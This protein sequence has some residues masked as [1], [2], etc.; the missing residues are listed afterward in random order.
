MV[1]LSRCQRKLGAGSASPSCGW[2]QL[3]SIQDCGHRQTMLHWEDKPSS[4]RLGSG[5]AARRVG[6]GWCSSKR[7]AQCNFAV[8]H[9]HCLTGPHPKCGLTLD[10]YMNMKFPVHME[11]GEKGP[12]L[13]CFMLSFPIQVRGRKHKKEAF[14]T[15]LKC[16][17]RDKLLKRSSL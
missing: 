5:H 9:L 11:S 15:H 7:G 14:M 6:L 2:H 4:G 16:W 17:V 3:T 8:G 10:T 12:G 13:P 1:R